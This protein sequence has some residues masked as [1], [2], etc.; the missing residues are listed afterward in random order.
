MARNTL[1]L[2]TAVSLGLILQACGTT[3]STA[4]VRE[5]REGRRINTHLE[6]PQLPQTYPDLPYLRDAAA[7]S[8]AVYVDAPA[9][10]RLAD[11]KSNGTEE[12]KA[13]LSLLPG[14]PWEE[15]TD[16]PR[17]IVPGRRQTPDLTYRL[18]VTTKTP[19]VALLVFRGT[20]IPADWISNLRWIDFWLPVEDHYEQ[21]ERVTR[22]IVDLI[23]ARYGA[24][25]TIFTAGHSLG[26]GLAQ[27]AAY[28]ACGD[29]RTV[30][31]F[32][33]SPVTKHRAANNCSSSPQ[34][35]YRVFEQSEILSYARFVVRLLLGLRGA[36]PHIAEVKVHLF[37]G[38]AVRAHSMQDLATKLDGA[39]RLTTVAESH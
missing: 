8:A 23:H 33:S 14:A 20:H 29:I 15:V 2:V 36:D 32:D 26:G 3:T 5:K 39:L 25:T 24:S 19:H 31:A 27:T 7:F 1:L 12:Q 30:F 34:T 38:V 17:T 6:I 13:S 16:I 22:S 28:A 9:T 4:T 11:V 18:W 37:N 35:F 10:Q 21:T